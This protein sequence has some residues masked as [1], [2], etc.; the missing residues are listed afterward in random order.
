MSPVYKNK[1]FTKNIFNKLRVNFLEQYKQ[2]CLI[3]YSV[4]NFNP[5][6]ILIKISNIWHNRSESP[7]NAVDNLKNK[8][9]CNYLISGN[10]L[11]SMLADLARPGRF[12]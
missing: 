2:V 1:C 6:Y 7:S 10:I 8:I 4:L 11:F 9:N 12:P 3:P 5:Y